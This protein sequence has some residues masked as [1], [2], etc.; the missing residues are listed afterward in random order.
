MYF[1][2]PKEIA[3][4]N[5]GIACVLVLFVSILSSM[6]GIGGGTLYMPLLLVLGVPFHQSALVSQFIILVASLSATLVYGR[7][8]RVDWKLALCI[9]P[10]TFTTAFIGGYFSSAV[11]VRMLK[12]VLALLL[13]SSGC[14]MLYPVHFLN[15]GGLLTGRRGW[16]RR[17]ANRNREYQV[18]LAILMPVTALAGL[19]AGAEGI[20]GGLLKVPAMVLLGDVPMDIAA[21]TSA[22]M[23]TFTAA[24]G[25]LGHLMAG[26]LN[27]ALALPLAVIASVGGHIGAQLAPKVGR[28]WLR[29]VFAVVIILIA[30]WLLWGVLVVEG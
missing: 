10:L 24:T 30:G 6:I 19:L 7:A 1:Y 29:R 4:L 12:G 3:T 27:L 16:H 23:V 9:E 25:L 17:F 28:K 14:L 2:Y 8:R 20:S 18:N 22:L 13:L 11:S 21:A 5:E 15:D 26:R